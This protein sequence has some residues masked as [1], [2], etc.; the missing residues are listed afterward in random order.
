MEKDL[1]YKKGGINV[2]AIV[3]EKKQILNNVELS[4]E[5]KPK[6]NRQ[7]TSTRNTTQQ[8]QFSLPNESHSGL[9]KNS[10]ITSSK[11]KLQGSKIGFKK[12]AEPFGPKN[13]A[14]KIRLIP[15]PRGDSKEGKRNT[16]ATRKLK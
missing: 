2:S 10:V 12:P 7:V 4:M 8:S 3:K 1:I 15:G 11:G 6:E 9:L 16:S 13:K 5:E 14:S